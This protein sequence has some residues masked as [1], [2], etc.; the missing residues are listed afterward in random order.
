MRRQRL[1][2]RLTMEA[3]G[4]V[5][6]VDHDGLG[7]RLCR[8]SLGVL[9]PDIC[10]SL[11]LSLPILLCPAIQLSFFPYSLSLSLSLCSVL[12]PYFLNDYYLF[13]QKDKQS[14]CST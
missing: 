14:A 7:F 5:V 6:S 9:P 4:P 3:W 1:T 2:D 11:S 10:S 13:S 8:M 12:F